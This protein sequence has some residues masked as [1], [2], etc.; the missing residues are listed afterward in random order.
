MDMDQ[1]KVE[2]IIHFLWLDF[3][4]K[5]NGVLDERLQ[6]FKSRIVKLHPGWQINFVDNWDK[7]VESVRNEPW[8]VRLLNNTHIGPAHKSD[9]LRYFYLYT[10]GG[11]WVDISTF[12]TTPFDDIVEKNGA[13]FTC[14]YMPSSECA[15]WLIKF[16]SDIVETI[17]LR[18]YAEIIEP[19]QENNIII[20]DKRF[21]LIPENYFLIC[22]SG[23]EVCQ[24]VIEQLEE[25]WTNAEPII[26]SSDDYCYE[27][28]KLIHR[29]FKEV[30][31]FNDDALPYLNLV[32][33][34]D[35]DK[36]SRVIYKNYFDCGYF[37]N[38]LQLYVAIHKY[39]I[40]YN[41]SIIHMPNSDAKTKIISDPKLSDFSKELCIHNSCDNLVI[42]CNNNINVNLLSASYN[43]LSK[44]SNDRNKRI[45]WENTLAGDILKKSKTAHEALQKLRDI[46]IEQLK[47]SSYTRSKS[48]SI[49]E[50]VKLFRDNIGYVLPPVNGKTGGGSSKKTIKK[51]KKTKKNSTRKHKSRRSHK[52][53]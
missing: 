28:N 46:D 4:N 11:V 43:R 32:D 9:A 37:F 49:N 3:T 7:C 52:S 33:I 20:K 5:K 34:A 50:L 16:T 31:N 40:K 8:L 25:Y 6:F 10:M 35:N 51:C 36:L 12:I 41:G 42:K 39:S 1:R 21:D 53:I 29:L 2:K 30:Y 15:S 47:Y 19:I 24:Y 18:E 48:E 23:N 26:K 27:N 13:G 38:Y 17:T 44:W 22:P 45:S 14:Y